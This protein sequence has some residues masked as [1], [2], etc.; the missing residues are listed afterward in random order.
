LKPAIATNWDDAVGVWVHSRLDSRWI[1]GQGN[2][3]G[4]VDDDNVLVAGVTYTQW[5]GT[6]IVMDVAADPKK[7]WCTPEILYMLFHFPF[8]QLNCTRVTAPVAASNT[9][10][11]RFVGKLGFTL[12]AT[13]EGACKDGDLLIYRMKKNECRWLENKP[14]VL[15]RIYPH[16]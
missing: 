12:E 3:I 14:D 10:C 1:S 15:P 16:G 4:V 9:R 11:R 13:L 2:A 5:T 6:N 7:F 8:V